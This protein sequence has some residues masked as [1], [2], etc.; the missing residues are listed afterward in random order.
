[1]VHFTIQRTHLHLIA[2]AE[3]QRALSSGMQGLLISAARRINRVLTKDDGKP[4]NGAVFPDRY[5]Q[6]VLTNPRQCRNA[7]RYVLSNFRRHSEDW[8]PE[9]YTWLLDKWS[10]AV[11]F[12]GWKGLADREQ[13]YPIPLDYERLPT[14]APRTWL[15]SLGWMKHGLIDEH[16]VPGPKETI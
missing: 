10:S 14:S 2:E 12:G 3:N 9:A 5:H 4:H 11:N 1:V 16:D 13:L 8:K 15:L 6:R 7:I